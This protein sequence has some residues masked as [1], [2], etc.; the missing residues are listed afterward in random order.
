MRSLLLLAEGKRGKHYN[1]NFRKTRN[2]SGLATPTNNKCFKQRCFKFASLTKW[3]RGFE[4]SIIL[5]LSS[6]TAEQTDAAAA[7]GDSLGAG[8]SSLC[9]PTTAP[10]ERAGAS[11]EA[12]SASAPAHAAATTA[13]SPT[14]R[15]VVLGCAVV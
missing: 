4:K 2:F 10:T 5:K 11:P 14:H 6:L 1:I 15:F 12:T 3:R 9:A 8:A 13:P 7:T